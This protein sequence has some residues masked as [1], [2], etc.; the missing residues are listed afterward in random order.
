EEPAANADPAALEMV[1]E[2][3]GGP[4]IAALVRKGA[5]AWSHFDNEATD[6]RAVHGVEHEFDMDVAVVRI[7]GMAV[8]GFDAADLYIP[9]IA[10]DLSGVLI[11]PTA[12]VIA[13]FEHGGKGYVRV[14]LLRFGNGVTV[15]E[16]IELADRGVCCV[17]FH[18]ATVKDLKSRL[19]D[20]ARSC[21]A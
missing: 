20:N 2:S 1:A 14:E 15:F 18:A 21:G 8:D 16:K 13:W 3:A 9:N 7:C 6:F 17:T 10:G 12:A 4:V 11:V 19:R 5:T